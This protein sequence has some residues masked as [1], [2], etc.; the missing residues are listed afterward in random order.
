VREID[1]SNHA[2][3]VEARSNPLLRISVDR[4]FSQVLDSVR[5]F[6][7]GS[8]LDA[9]CGEGHAVSPLR[10]LGVEYTGLDA[11]SACVD[12]CR[13]RHPGLPFSTASVLALPFAARSFDVVLCMEVLEHLAEPAVAVRELA[14]VTRRGL[15][16]TVPFE[17][18]FQIGNAARGKYRASWGNHPEHIQHW[19]WRSFPRFLASTAALDEVTVRAA[20]PWLVAS[21]RPRL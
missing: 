5:G 15:V 11:N 1:T 12:Y 9:G 18:L 10:S 7:P 20:G 3:Y 17:P 14:R 4:L 16:F 8:L 13:E 19:G 21:A 2:K 6:A